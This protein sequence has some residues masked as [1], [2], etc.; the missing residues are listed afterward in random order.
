MASGGGGGQG[1]AVRTP[2]LIAPADVLSSSAIDAYALIQELRPSWLRSHGTISIRD[3]STGDVQVFLNGQQMGDVS[4][5]REIAKREIREVK[6]YNPGQAHLRFGMGHAGGVID[7]ATG[8]TTP[9][10]PPPPPAATEPDTAAAPAPPASEPP[11]RLSPR[12]Q[13]VLEPEEFEGTTA[14]DVLALVQ[15][16]RPNWLRGRGTTSIYDPNAGDV[17][18]Y[19]NG[20]W[21]G[22]VNRLHDFRVGEVREL[23]FLNA[24]DAQQRY[25][26]GNGGGVIEIVLK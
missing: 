17:K 8:A 2:S 6:F 10:R 11:R 16:F 24:G 20:V 15:E 9:S 14:A 23:R 22:D 25:G 4:R 3:P 26:S 5:L 18:V 7:V 1:T 13:G 12:N 21:A 19:V